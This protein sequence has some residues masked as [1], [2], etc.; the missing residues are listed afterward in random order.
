MRRMPCV[1]DVFW[2]FATRRMCEVVLRVKVA[3]L[4]NVLDRRDGEWAHPH[5]KKFLF[6]RTLDGMATS[7]DIHHVL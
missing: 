4:I 3:E 5:K 6:V 7:R 2:R 1:V